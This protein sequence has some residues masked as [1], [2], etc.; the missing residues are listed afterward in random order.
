MTADGTVEVLADHVDGERI[1]FAS[2]VAAHPDGTIWFTTSTRRWTL[3]H[4]EGDFIEHSCT[5][6]LL[7][8][9]ADGTVTTVLDGLGFA[10]GLVLA[11]DGTHLLFAETASYRVSRFWLTG[12]RA[13]TVEVLVDNLPAFPDNMSLG[14]DGLLWVAMVA[15]RTKALDALLPLP[16]LL[17]LVV[18][19]LPSMLR[20][21]PAPIAWVMAYDLDGNL[22]HDIRSTEC[23]YGFVTAVAERDGRIVLGSL[24]E[25]DVA[26]VRKPGT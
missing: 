6:R 4:Y 17:R 23:G 14:S 7:R 25:A 18:W 16:G 21:K 1:R 2:N 20:P 8:R 13:G 22:V 11:S 3:G 26:V 15:P 19:N 5:G 10:N 24:T 12:P 9:D